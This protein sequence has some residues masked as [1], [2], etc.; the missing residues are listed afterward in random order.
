[1]AAA[2]EWLTARRP[3]PPGS[4]IVRPGTLLSAIA[5]VLHVILKRV[6]DGVVPKG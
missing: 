4:P 2:S 6:A 3:S 1:M 5:A